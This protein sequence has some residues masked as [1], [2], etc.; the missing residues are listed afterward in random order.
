M[1]FG[2]GSSGPSSAELAAQS[3][4]AQDAAK[5]EADRITAEK[6]L[7][8]HQENAKLVADQ[9]SVANADAA[10]RIRNRTLLAGIGNE[11]DKSTLSLED[12]ASKSAKKAKRATLLGSI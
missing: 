9:A 8:K 11:E 6:D 3:K 5:A 2:G 4:A 7:A 12:P 10:R 1:C